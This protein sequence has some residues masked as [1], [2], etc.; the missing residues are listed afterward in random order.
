M[1]GIPIDDVQEI[2]KI[3]QI[4][5]TLEFSSTPHYVVILKDSTSLCTCM[6]IINQGMPCRH[7]YRVLLQSSGAVFHITFINNRWFEKIPSDTNIVISQGIKSS[8]SI[9][10]HYIE[11]IRPTNVSI[12]VIKENINKK[13][14]FGTAM[15]LAKTS[16]QIAISESAVSELIGILMQFNMKYRHNTGF[17][18]EETSRA[19]LS[20]LDN[21][22]NISNP[23]Y[24]R[25]KGRPPKR[26]KSSTEENNA[27]KHS[28]SKKC[29]YCFEMGHNIRGCVKYK[30]DRNDKENN[31]NTS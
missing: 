27:T 19:P 14:Q 20:N 10:L 28:S 13:V 30:T 18:M 9:V 31:N 11:Q 24:H 26:Y 4:C 29:S 22:Y 2:W 23:E 8:T 16:V 21:N 6:N 25:P 7:Q 15:S 5:T 12:P 3:F 1:F 17:G